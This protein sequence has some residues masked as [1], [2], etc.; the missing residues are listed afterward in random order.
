MTAPRSG[1][2]LRQK[3]CSCTVFVFVVN[4]Q[5]RVWNAQGLFWRE[6]L[7]FCDGMPARRHR[8]PDHQHDDADQQVSLSDTRL[9]TDL[10]GQNFNR[11]VAAVTRLENSR[12]MGLFVSEGNFVR[13][14][15]VNLSGIIS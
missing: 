4:P 1:K 14:T 11:M 6:V 5:R 8:A 13:T 2:Q 7:E 10:I 12:S 15:L 9:T 3:P